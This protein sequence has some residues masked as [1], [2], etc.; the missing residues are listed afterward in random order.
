MML[1]AA[2]AARGLP[3]PLDDAAR[4]GFESRFNDIPA[5]AQKANSCGV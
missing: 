3:W 4:Q 1:L 5:M 2:L